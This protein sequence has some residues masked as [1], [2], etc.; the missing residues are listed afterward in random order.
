MNNIYTVIKV[1][2]QGSIIKDRLKGKYLIP[3]TTKINK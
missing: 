3:T 2:D 1:L